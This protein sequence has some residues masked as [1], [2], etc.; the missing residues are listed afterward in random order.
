MLKVLQ[1]PGKYVQGPNALYEIAEYI[2]PLGKK[3]LFIADQFVFGLV[4]S[5]LQESCQ[6]SDIA[7]HKAVFQGEC[8][9]NEIKRLGDLFA[10]SGADIVVG[11]GG[12]KTLDAAKAVAYYGGV[13]IVIAPTIASTD[14]PTSALSVIYTDNGEFESYLLYPKNPDVVVMDTTIIANAPVRLFVAGMGD[15]LA[16]YFEARACTDAQKATMAGGLTTRAA[17]ALAELCYQTLLEE[18]LKAKFAVENRVSTKAV[19]DIVEANTLLSGL[20]FESAGL[21]A[22]HAIHNGLTVIEECHEMYH[23][24][25]VAFG[26][27][28]QLILENSP[29][30]ELEEVL[31]FSTAV[32]LPVTLAQLG[33]NDDAPRY[34]ERLKEAAKLSCAEAD[35]IHN[36]PFN[37]TEEDV[38]A[39]IIT[40]DRL[41]RAWL[42]SD[43][44]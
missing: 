20:G 15:A 6:K 13:P 12:G 10:Q 31:S 3:A 43:E 26:V 40:A 30:E 39:A 35:T 22:C 18:G 29:L 28:V 16:T 8:S 44:A 33:L 5:M 38:Y 14:A 34:H 2:K 21:A 9:Q 19:E 17:M 11:V 37:V 36:M 32:G 1:S 27:L 42:N 25:K 23:G 4:E 24:E 41:G 7:Y